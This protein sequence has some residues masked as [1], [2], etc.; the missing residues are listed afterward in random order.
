MKAVLIRHDVE[1]P[2]THI[3]VK[4]AELVPGVVPDDVTEATRLTPYAVQEQY[5]DT[6]ADVDAEHV[7]DAVRLAK[8]VVQWAAGIIHAD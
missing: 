2:K 4:L 6:F 5:P 3:L 1:F 7:D 8:A